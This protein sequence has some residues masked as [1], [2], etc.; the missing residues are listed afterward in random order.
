MASSSWTAKQNKL[1]ENAL[2]IYDKDAPDR[3][4]NLAR[5]VGGKTVEEVKRHYEMLVEDVNKIE[6]GEVPLP[7]YRKIGANNKAYNSFMDE[8]QRMRNLKLQ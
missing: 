6:S 5:A 7:N 8:E 1:F 2:A 3:W 4:H